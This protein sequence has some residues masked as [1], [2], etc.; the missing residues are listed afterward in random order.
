M[1]LFIDSTQ[2]G[3]C[4]V[5]GVQHVHSLQTMTRRKVAEKNT[6]QWRILGWWLGGFPRSAVNLY[7][8]PIK[9][10]DIFSLKIRPNIFHPP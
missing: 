9:I 7:F 4:R 6:Q 5:P 3:K 1:T 8:F 2:L 10:I